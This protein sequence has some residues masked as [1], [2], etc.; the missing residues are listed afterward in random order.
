MEQIQL[1]WAILSALFAF[2]LCRSYHLSLGSSF[3]IAVGG[4]LVGFYLGLLSGRV[5]VSNHS[6]RLKGQFRPFV[7]LSSMSLMFIFAAMFLYVVAA[8]VV[9][10]GSIVSR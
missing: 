4:F 2:S 9:F 3:G 10:V 1:I 7:R 6:A 5:L 8:L